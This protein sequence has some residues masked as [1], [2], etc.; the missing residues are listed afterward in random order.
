[1]ARGEAKTSLRSAL[2]LA[3]DTAAAMECRHTFRLPVAHDTDIVRFRDRHGR[4]A[5]RAVPQSE[6]DM[7]RFSTWPVLQYTCILIMSTVCTAHADAGMLSCEVLSQSHTHHAQPEMHA[8]GLSGDLSCWCLQSPEF[9]IA[10]WDGAG[11]L[12]LHPVAYSSDP[13][14]NRETP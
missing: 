12:P 14:G 6:E 1:M 7:F 9:R 11:G 3:Q 5:P 4:S 10:G 8:R 2:P 13:V